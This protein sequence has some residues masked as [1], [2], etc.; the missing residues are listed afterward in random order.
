MKWHWRGQHRAITGQRRHMK[1]NKCQWR[2]TTANASHHR[3]ITSQQRYTK[4]HNGQWRPMQGCH[5]PMK[6]QWPMQANTGLFQANKGQWRPT[7]ANA[8]Q[9]RAVI[10]DRYDNGSRYYWY[11]VLWSFFIL[12]KFFFGL[13]IEQLYN[14]VCSMYNMIKILYIYIVVHRIEKKLIFIY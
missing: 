13:W 9:H 7:T 14:N 12:M 11:V 5:R 1:A 10:I 2:C 8:S 6:A 4:V 3:A